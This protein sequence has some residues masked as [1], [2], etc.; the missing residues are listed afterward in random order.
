LLYGG[1]GALLGAGFLAGALVVV[2]R[3]GAD[4]D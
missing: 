1:V 3:R 4:S 2:R